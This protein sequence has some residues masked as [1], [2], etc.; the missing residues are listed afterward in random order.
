MGRLPRASGRSDANTGHHTPRPR[1]AMHVRGDRVQRA[2]TPRLPPALILP[3]LLAPH[4]AETA[5]CYANGDAFGSE[6]VGSP[7]HALLR[8]TIKFWHANTRTG[9]AHARRQAP[10]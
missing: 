5:V 10:A 7:G 8:S 2:Y 3:L 4:G 1:A 9:T 6:A